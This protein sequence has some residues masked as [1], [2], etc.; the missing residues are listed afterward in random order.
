MIL[1]PC[2]DSFLVWRCGHLAFVLSACVQSVV[3]QSPAAHAGGAKRWPP[4][5]AAAANA[6]LRGVRTT[7]RQREAVLGFQVQQ[8]CSTCSCSCS[9]ALTL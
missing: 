1:L 6:G 5:A 3:A 8:Y 4:A 9:L 2:S 7:T